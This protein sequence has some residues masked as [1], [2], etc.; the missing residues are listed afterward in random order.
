VTNADQLTAV[1]FLSLIMNFAKC[2]KSLFVLMRRALFHTVHH[3]T[4]QDLSLGP[5][6]IV[7]N[8]TES[9]EILSVTFFTKMFLP[10]K[11][12]RTFLHR[13]KYQCEFYSFSSK[14]NETFLASY[15]RL[16]S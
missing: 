10:P 12:R 8:I 16:Q 6:F 5:S 3:M 11:H 4:D 14:E 13:T 15:I 9:D 2:M 7:S 1:I